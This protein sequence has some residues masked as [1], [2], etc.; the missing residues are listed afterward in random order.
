MYVYSQLAGFYTNYAFILIFFV[1]PTVYGV[2]ICFVHSF[3]RE[4]AQIFLLA[5]ESFILVHFFLFSSYFR[6]NRVGTIPPLKMEANWLETSTRLPPFPI[7]FRS[8]D[9]SSDFLEWSGKTCS[10]QIWAL[11]LS[12]PPGELLG[13]RQPSVGSATT[14]KSPTLTEGHQPANR[15]RSVCRFESLFQ[16]G[17]LLQ[18]EFAFLFSRKQTFLFFTLSYR[19]KLISCPYYWTKIVNIDR[20]NFYRNP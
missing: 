3:V 8:L 9:F 2:I 4:I 1:I 18:N 17:V 12:S 19:S 11:L 15:R 5:F 14:K 7:K 10:W 6:S 13:G 20:Q 16:N